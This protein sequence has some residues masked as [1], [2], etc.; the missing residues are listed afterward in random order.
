M[1]N[2]GELG[3]DRMASIKMFG[4]VN[5]SGEDLLKLIIPSVCM[6]EKNSKTAKHI[7]IKFDI[8]ESN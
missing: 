3:C 2:Y 7:F 6:Q 8:W 5:I 4:H 1:F